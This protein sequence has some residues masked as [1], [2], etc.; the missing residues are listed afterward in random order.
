MR[1]TKIKGGGSNTRFMLDDG[2]YIKCEGEFS[3]SR[4][5]IYRNSL[6]KFYY[7]SFYEMSNQ[8]KFDFEAALRRYKVEK[9]SSAFEIVFE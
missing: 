5:L 9:L 8:Q 7:D 1:V 3:L 4:F 2:S 6:R